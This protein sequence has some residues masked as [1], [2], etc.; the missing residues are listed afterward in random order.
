MTVDVVNAG[1]GSGKTYYLVE[2]LFDRI[3]EGHEPGRILATTFTRAAAAELKTR[4]QAKVLQSSLGAGQ[5]QLIVEQLE[6]AP[7]G[8]VHSVGA[9]IL[10]RFAIDR[11]LSPRLETLHESGAAAAL[12]DLINSGASPSW[13]QLVRYSR[14]IGIEDPRKLAGALV[15]TARTNRIEWAD[16]RTQLE[17]SAEV[18]IA[19]MGGVEGA[20]NSLNPEAVRRRLED[21]RD[22][23]K[24]LVG[25]GSG[26]V[27]EKKLAKI[28]GLLSGLT[29]QWSDFLKAAEEGKARGK[30]LKG[31]VE[32]LASLPDEVLR[33]S[34]LHDDLRAFARA[35]ADVSADLGEAY[36]R[37]KDERGLVDFTDQ[38]TLFLDLL[39]D[40][41]MAEA[42]AREIGIVAIDEF[43]DTNPIQL[44]IFTELEVIADRCLWVGDGKQAIYGFRDT[45]PELVERAWAV[46]R[47]E[48]SERLAHNR[49]SCSGLVE[50][51]GQVF[52][53]IF[54]DDAVQQPD[55]TKIN[56]RA[57]ERWV[58]E[59]QNHT[60]DFQALAT[61][62]Q[63]LHGEG[64]R[65]GDIALLVRKND[66][67]Q[68][69]ATAFRERGIPVRAEMPGLLGH[70]EIA[71][72]VAGLSI[73]AD[74]SDSLSP[75]IVLH[76]LGEHW[77]GAPAW[78]SSRLKERRGES[79][80][81]VLPFTDVAELAAL[82]KINREVG[83]LEALHRVV[84][85]LRI[86]EH[87]GR[88]GQ[89]A[90]R[91]TNIDTLLALAGD[92]EDEC[93]AAGGGASVAGLVAWLK[94]LEDGT[95]DLI[96]PAEGVDALT[97]TTY[98]KAKG[99][100]WE[101]TVLFDLNEEP[102]PRLWEQPVAGGGA[103]AAAPL[104]DRRIDL[105]P[106]PFG[107]SKKNSELGALA[108][109][110]PRGK[111]AAQR[112]VDEI[113]RLLYVGMTRAKDLLIFA[114]RRGKTAWLD[115]SVELPHLLPVDPPEGWP[116]DADRADGI[117]V[118]IQD[119][120]T[121]LLLRHLDLPD[122]E[123]QKEAGSTTS[124]W[125]E[126]TVEQ[127]EEP[128]NRYANPSDQGQADGWRVAE[129][130]T[131]PGATPGGSGK[132]QDESLRR[133][134][135]NA[136][137]DYLA[138]LPS[139]SGLG[140]EVKLGVATRSIEARAM[141][142]EIAPTEIVT[143][144]DAFAEWADNRY[145]GAV[146]LTEA[147]VTA[148]R[149]EGGQWRGAIDLV[150]DLGDSSLVVIDHKSTRLDE[151]GAA[152]AALH[153]AGQIAAYCEAL[154]TQGYSVESGW[155]HFPLSGMVVRLENR[156]SGEGPE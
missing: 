108:D 11:G 55:P 60:N 120:S 68:K 140:D 66:H 155:I 96:Q 100:E 110:S 153:H 107:K 93:R 103:G 141:E 81:Q 106:W 89:A 48:D 86:P 115:Q 69:A 8:T 152:P 53:P 104:V 17:R 64:R 74:R 44:A 105:W 20:T 150:L 92:Y 91:C 6:L 34:V 85:A 124:T 125:L 33:S 38:E 30:E 77:E 73:V 138:A 90:Q 10:G 4:L 3:L 32:V 5:A 113:R 65:W 71:L 13:G 102:K 87:F 42:L 41:K 16:L 9:Q 149:E 15:A 39:R 29:G 151:S 79:K 147:P 26:S 119:I 117:E 31:I 111:A 51:V 154:E 142:T 143:A 27:A 37:Y 23:L 19:T 98:H 24:E 84:D 114:H 56:G 75:A 128:T 118:E 146:W 95:K 61:G 78:L 109:A 131:L 133:D 67:L 25:R 35:A 116:E 136:V 43:Q 144:G 12:D 2:W 82:R 62:L 134:I 112:E 123:L 101:V 122:E 139:L 88:W 135:G 97:I 76:L 156:D 137:H 50:L 59:T 47:N 40:P 49:R 58:L 94:S 57:V 45:D 126:V 36:R 70:R 99:L 127:G 83:P 121:N 28:V 52:Q 129:V 7:M 132:K 148:P 14:R 18:L 1:A 72:A 22:Q 63:R 46:H 54:G 21:I 130:M 145:P 80:T